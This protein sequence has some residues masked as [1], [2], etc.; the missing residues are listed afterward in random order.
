ME[1]IFKETD[2]KNVYPN[3]TMRNNF[4]SLEIVKDGKW[5]K[6]EDIKDTKQYQ[7]GV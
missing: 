2:K 1:M 7:N 3:G 6:V 4:G 5:V